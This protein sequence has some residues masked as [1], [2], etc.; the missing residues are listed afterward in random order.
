MVESTS[1][2]NTNQEYEL[3]VYSNSTNLMYFLQY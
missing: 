1:V 3:V 2:G